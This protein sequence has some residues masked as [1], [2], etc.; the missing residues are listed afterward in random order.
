MFLSEL[1]FELGLRVEA[2]NPGN[3]RNKVLDMIINDA[4]TIKRDININEP[5]NRALDHLGGI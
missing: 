5:I 2:V 3:K 1:E 4:K